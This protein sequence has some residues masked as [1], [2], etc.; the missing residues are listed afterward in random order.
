[1][2]R[3]IHGDAAWGQGRS[4]S[5]AST[6][7]EREMLPAGLGRCGQGG[8]EMQGRAG[9]LMSRRS[10][11]ANVHINGRTNSP[12]YP[13]THF[14]VLPIK[15]LLNLNSDPHAVCNFP[16]LIIFVIFVDFLFTIFFVFFIVLFIFALD[17]RNNGFSDCSNNKSD[18]QFLIVARSRHGCRRAAPAPRPCEAH[19]SKSLSL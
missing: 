6:Q 11:A 5:A 4:R 9:R 10:P 1:M 16:P 13:P 14:P 12:F 18:G 2:T 8:F 17:N 7:I 3:V 19:G 15:V